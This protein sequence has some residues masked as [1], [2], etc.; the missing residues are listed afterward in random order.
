MK[1]D[2]KEV[3]DAA[4]KIF[5]SAKC[6][7][8][9]RDLLNC[10]VKNLKERGTEKMDNLTVVP[11]DGIVTGTH[12]DYK[13]TDHLFKISCN[14]KIGNA[15]RNYVLVI[16]DMQNEYLDYVRY[17][18][19][20]VKPLIDQFREKKLPIIWTNWAR[21]AE[22]GYYGAL[23]RFYGP[24]GIKDEHNPCYVYAKDAHHTVDELAPRNASEISRSIVSLHLSKFADYDEEGREILF[25]MLEAW[26]VNTI[27]LC[28]AWTDDCIAATAFDAADKYGYD[29][30]LVNDGCAT[31]T[32]NGGKMMDVLYA[33]TCCSM[34]CEEIVTHLKSHP[35]LIEAPKAPLD[36]NVRLRPT[37]YR[38]DAALAEVARLKSKVA[39]LES[40]LALARAENKQRAEKN[41]DLRID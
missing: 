17:R 24:Q 30:I 38:H 9:C 26:G 39:Q 12:D 13:A 21:R 27:I 28:G 20:T 40:E 25:P 23:D 10:V 36:G 6:D 14:Y 22:D 19:P 32:T 2:V 41:N 5:A 1:S 7:P 16:E 15:K 4:E 37:Q 11:N 8:G 29:V 33:S 31:A 34:S 3:E 35:E 18:I